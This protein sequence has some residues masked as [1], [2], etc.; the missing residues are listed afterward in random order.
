MRKIAILSAATGFLLS[1]LPTGIYAHSADKEHM[2]ALQSLIRR[3][4]PYDAETPADS[5]ISWTDRLAPTLKHQTDESYFSLLLWQVNAYIMRGDISLAIDRAR[6]MYEHAK[7]MKSNFGIALSN[8]AIG[9]AYSASYVQDKALS[10]YLD[11]LHHLPDNNPQI[12]RL[13]VKISTLLQQ[14]NQMEESLRYLQQLNTLLEQQPEH[15]LAI[16]ILIENATYYIASGKP[17]TALRF[18]QQADSIYKN[19]THELAHELPIN[20][21]TAACYRVL[22]AQHQDMRKADE[23]LTLYEKLLERVSTNKRSPEYR[24]ICEEK[25]KLYKMLGRYDD[26]SQI[27]KEL[28][29]VTDT[30]ASKSYIRQINALKATYQI[31][32]LESGNKAQLNQ[33]VVTSIF[34]GLS[35][36]AFISLLAIWLKKQQQIVTRSKETLEQSRRNAENATRAKSVFLSNMS[37]EIRTPLNALSGFSSLLT[38][39]GLDDATRQ[40]CTEIIQQNSELLLKLINDVIDLSSLEF[41]KMQFSMGKYDA[42]AICRNVADTVG[43]VK[44]TQAELTFASSLEELYIETDD[45]RLQQ[46]LIN[47]LINATKFTPDGSITLQLEKQSEEMALFSVTDTG[48][49][50]PK[51]KQAHIFQR[52]EKLNENAQ[53]SGLGLSIC[54]LI[55]EHIG[56]N[57]WIDPEY[58]GGSRFLFTHPVSQPHGTIKKEEEHS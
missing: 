15:P 13:L 45:S 10:S 27:Y 48:C 14:M 22:A 12:Y 26:A 9:Q 31:D 46:V 17:E 23:A 40:Q 2:D 6:L 35:L 49:G 58:T 20:F 34:I 38:E 52:F 53:G 55:I 5:I 19:H 37:H 39:E 33:I 16:P 30:L 3:E 47:L 54:Q 36:V 42:V 41:G 4:V 29:S 43:K 57:I 21:Y 11:A 18:L 51:E 8:Q 1:F 32:E 28:C 7:D 44:Q 25:I 50:I 24:S 56:G